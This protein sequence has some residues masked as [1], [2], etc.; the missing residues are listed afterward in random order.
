M[1][2]LRTEF[3]RT[4]AAGIAN[5]HETQRCWAPWGL[6]GPEAQPSLIHHVHVKKENPFYGFPGD[7]FTNVHFSVIKA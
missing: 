2:G 3:L 7:L 5:R 6:S 4:G 1:W